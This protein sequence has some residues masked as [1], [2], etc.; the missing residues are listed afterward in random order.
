MVLKGNGDLGLDFAMGSFFC[1][2]RGFNYR[3]VSK[4]Q[5]IDSTC[6]NIDINIPIQ[7]YNTVVFKRGKLKLFF[8]GLEIYFR[9]FIY[10]AIYT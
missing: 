4:T 10:D 7:S 6:F 2:K 1:R 8:D 9:S 3:S 5:F